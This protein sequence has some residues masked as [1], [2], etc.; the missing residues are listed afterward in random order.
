MRMLVLGGAEIPF[1]SSGCYVVKNLFLHMLNKRRIDKGKGFFN[2]TA[3][4]KTK[5]AKELEQEIKEPLLKGD[6][7]HKL[8]VM[9]II[10]KTDRE[11]WI[12]VLQWGE[13]FLTSNEGNTLP[14]F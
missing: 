5:S 7:L 10:R 9:E 6:W 4:L 12:D 8:A 11:L 1:D 3:F 2:I 13:N 14:Q